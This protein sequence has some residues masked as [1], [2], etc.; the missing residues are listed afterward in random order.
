M[1]IQVKGLSK[2]FRLFKREAGLKGAITSFFNR[3]YENFHALKDISIKDPGLILNSFLNDLIWEIV[4]IKFSTSLLSLSTLNLPVGQFFSIKKS[5]LKL[6][7]LF[8][9]QISSV[10]NGINGCDNTNI[11]LKI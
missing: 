5:L 1:P 3:K 10:I 8:F 4:C 7:I 2:H 9:S 6:S 11:S